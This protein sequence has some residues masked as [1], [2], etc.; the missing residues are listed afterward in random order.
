M[1]LGLL[2]GRDCLKTHYSSLYFG[3]SVLKTDV[4]AVEEGKRVH[5]LSRN[6]AASTTALPK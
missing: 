4:L 5:F 6:H 3:S 2:L 1:F